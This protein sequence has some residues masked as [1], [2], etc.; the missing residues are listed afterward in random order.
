LKHR[1][2]GVSNPNPNSRSFIDFLCELKHR[3]G[4]VS[5][6][7]ARIFVLKIQIL[8]QLAFYHDFL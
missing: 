4:G 8:K 3:H 6:R 5:N 7:Q 2:G 1:H